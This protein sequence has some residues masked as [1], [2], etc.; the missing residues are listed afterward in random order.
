MGIDIKRYVRKWRRKGGQEDPETS[1]GSIDYDINKP[2]EISDYIQKRFKPIFHWFKSR[3]YANAHRFRLWRISVIALTLFIVIF[4]ISSL[5]YGSGSSIAATIASSIA[6]VLILGSTAFVQ[7]T[8]T[9]ENWLLFG[10]ASQRLEREYQLFMLKASI[11]S[12]TLAPKADTT[13][14]IEAE[15]DKSKDKLF[16]ENIENII[17]SHTTESRFQAL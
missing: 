17:S 8:R 11:Y 13:P 12:T 3:A 10:T 14:S 5:G 1:S 7:L 9:Q 16:V 2:I 15:D 4:D 6:A